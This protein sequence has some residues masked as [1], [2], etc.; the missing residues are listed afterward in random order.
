MALDR[1]LTTEV[2]GPQF[3][4][5]CKLTLSDSPRATRDVDLEL[6]RL[7]PLPARDVG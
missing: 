1:G 5:D 7:V 4:P 6:G 2:G 3:G